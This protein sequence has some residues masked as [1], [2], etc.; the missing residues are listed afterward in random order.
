M[1]V[2]AIV[3]TKRKEGLVSR[4]WRIILEGAIAVGLVPRVF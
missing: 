3:G 2:L 1:K 4:M